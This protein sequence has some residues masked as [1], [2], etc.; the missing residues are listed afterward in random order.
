MEKLKFKEVLYLAQSHKIVQ[1]SNLYYSFL[2]LGNKVPPLGEG[3]PLTLCSG[4]HLFLLGDLSFH[5][6]LPVIYGNDLFWAISFVP[7]I[8]CVQKSSYIRNLFLYPILAASQ[9]NENSLSPT[10]ITVLMEG[11]VYTQ[12]PN[13]LASH[14]LPSHCNLASISNISPLLLLPKSSMT[15]LSLSI[16]SFLILLGFSTVVNELD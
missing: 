7:A 15:S 12:C 2:W 10:L 4:S 1:D 5:Q 9:A 3:Q 11:V 13:F 16:I 8:K 14:S 6:L